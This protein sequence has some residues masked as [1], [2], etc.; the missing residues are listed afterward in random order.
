LRVHEPEHV[1]NIAGRELG[2][3]AG[4]QVLFLV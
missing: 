3:E 4:L 1:G 2:V